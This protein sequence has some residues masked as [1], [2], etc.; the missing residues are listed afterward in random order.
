MNP[1]YSS[2][3]DARGALLLSAGYCNKLC[4]IIRTTVS[5]CR[6]I[7]CYSDIGTKGRRIVSPGSNTQIQLCLEAVARYGDPTCIA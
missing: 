1:H 3:M 7:V 5:L 2:I 4:F 6:A